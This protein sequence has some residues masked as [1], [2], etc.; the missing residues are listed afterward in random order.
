[1]TESVSVSYMCK[2][3]ARIACFITIAIIFYSPWMGV[4]NP[5]TGWD[6]NRSSASWD[7]PHWHWDGVDALYFAMVTMTTVGYGDM[8]SISQEMRIFTMIY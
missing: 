1:M 3:A 6:A 8:P 2:H 7:T 5:I 4:N